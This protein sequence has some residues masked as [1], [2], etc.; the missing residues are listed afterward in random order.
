MAH[1]HADTEIL[2][3]ERSGKTGSFMP[4]NPPCKVH[5][6]F[7]ETFSPDQVAALLSEAAQ[8]MKSK[9]KRQATTSSAPGFLEV[10]F[11]NSTF[12]FQGRD[13]VEAP[14]SE[15]LAER[16]LGE[17][18]GGGSGPESCHLDIEVTDLEQA[19]KVIRHTLRELGFGADVRIHQRKPI[20]K[21]YRI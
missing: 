12:P 3:Y 7:D 2:L 8:R 11:R 13:K 14:L 5:A 10:V 15:A 1:S 21:L 9:G 6:L 17:I 16:E 19:L 4:Q 20:R 18:T